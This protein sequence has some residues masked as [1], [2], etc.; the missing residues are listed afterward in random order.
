MSY[1][2]HT[3]K[4]SASA[5]VQFADI[6]VELALANHEPRFRLIRLNAAKKL[7]LDVLRDVDAAINVETQNMKAA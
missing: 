1:T 3:S 2:K 4:A 7:L 5:Q 6:I